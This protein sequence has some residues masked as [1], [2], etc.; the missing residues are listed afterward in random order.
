MIRLGI[1][2]IGELH[3][4]QRHQDAGSATALLHLR[5]T[6]EHLA[7]HQILCYRIPASVVR[8]ACAVDQH[9]FLATIGARARDLGMRLTA[10]AGM[11]CAL[12]AADHESASASVAGLTQ[13]ANVLDALGCGSAGTIVVHLVGSIHDS[14]VPVRFARRYA[15]LPA[16]V[17]QRLAIEPDGAGWSLG[18]LHVL[19]V[20]CGIP[21]VLDALHLQLNNP[22]RIS[23][24][25]A[26]R[27]AL[28]SWPTDVRPKVHLST[29]RTEAHTRPGRAGQAYRIIAPR[30]GE[31]ADF[32]NPFEAGALLAAARGARPFDLMIEARAGDL[33][34][35]RLREDLDRYQPALAALVG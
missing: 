15:A 27:I 6:I 16:Q 4:G 3:A 23:V 18:D 14:Q 34:L 13:I 24:A 26:L 35:I 2:S 19:H 17:Q 32:L 11:G 31:H 20:Q 33:A 30:R 28:G 12:G 21:I 29:Q 10:H 9:V 5:D 25:E 22:Q 7:R 8:A 1:A